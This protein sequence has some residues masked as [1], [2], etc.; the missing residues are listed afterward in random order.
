MARLGLKSKRASLP[1]TLYYVSAN[2]FP[3]VLCGEL[4]YLVISHDSVADDVQVVPG[5]GNEECA[6]LFVQAKR[7]NRPGPNPSGYSS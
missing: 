5:L 2:S 6:G 1:A 7:S 3:A 4:R